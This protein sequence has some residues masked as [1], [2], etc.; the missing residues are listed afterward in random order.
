V[1]TPGRT[2]EEALAGTTIESVLRDGAP[3]RIP[4]ARYT[5]PEWAALEAERLWPR[6]WQV[7]CTK[8]HVAEPGDWFE[9]T[10]GPLSVLVVR[11]DDGVLRAFQ[12]VCQHRGNVLC[13][14]SG[15]GLTELRCPYHRWAWTLAGDLREIPSRRGFGGIRNDDLPL[16]RAA[17]DTWGELV[18]VN[19]QRDAE[20]LA[21]FLEGVPDDIAWCGIDE[22]RCLVTA[23]V[24]LP[25]NWKTLIDAFSETYHV[26]GIHPEMLGSTDDVNS[27]QRL[28]DRH[29]KLEQPYGIPSPRL[30]SATDE[31]VW[32]SFVVTQGMRV[33]V[34]DE[35]APL[36]ARAEGQSVRD[37]LTDL[38]R[39]R[40]T[41]A[42]CTVPDGWG[43]R[44]LLD[45][46]QYNLFPNSTVIYTGDLLS[47][48]AARPGPSPDESVMTN[49]YF[50]RAPSA[51]APRPRPTDLVLP[52]DQAR[53]G[54]VFE[55]DVANLGRA[56]R[57]L[58][59]PGL[60]HLTLS[61]EEARIVNLHRNLDRYLAPA[62][63]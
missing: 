59:Q 12:N 63:P 46:H 61:V 18:F 41:D 45:L 54:L 26:Q 29:G 16:V 2:D 36:P 50:Q 28:W 48:T 31:D 20:P 60:T 43:A 14:G 11:G 6:T 22:F 19:L 23:A 27:P 17:V 58:H 7:A 38:V 42:G 15:S 49:Y 5:S 34:V 51:S 1:G 3:F 33:G 24:V 4:A 37:L 62:T 52:A 13:V 25:C 35:A 9:Y 57:G 40:L 32:R 30:R 44:E 8:S 10:C 53:F 47:V 39:R 21:E 56:Q 55:Q